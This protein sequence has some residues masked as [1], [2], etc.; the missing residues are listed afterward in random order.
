M[1]A[2][3][4]V[5]TPPARRSRTRLVIPVLSALV[6]VGLV[7]LLIYGVIARSPRTG[8]DESLAQARPASAPPF[9]LRVLRRG[10]LGTRLSPAVAP[11]LADGWVSPAELRGTPYVLNIWASWCVPCREEAPLLQRTWQ[12][13]RPKGVLFLGVNQQDVPEDA[14]AFM[15][16]FGVDYLNI[17]DPS[18]RTARSYGATGIPETYFVSRRGQIVGHVIGV[19]SAQQMRSGLAA[20]L[21][22]RPLA[23]REGGARRAL[24]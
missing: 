11:A 4:A 20:A 8:I 5:A 19:I 6:A 7:S 18:N 23:V 17:R 21:S 1:D 10:D 13:Q 22:G 16:E 12:Q 9:R 3:P 2:E 15:D 24:R 14:N